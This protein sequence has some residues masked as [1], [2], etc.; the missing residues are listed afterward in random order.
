MRRQK[1]L[2][3]VAIVLALVG[4]ISVYRYL[5]GADQR[6]LAG[7]RP[8]TVLMV[9][10]RI[11]EGTTVAK[12][13]S[14]GYVHAEEVPAESVPADALLTLSDIAQNETALDDV[15]AGQ[16][17]VR[18]MFG[19]AGPTTSGLTIPDGMVAVSVPVNADADV[20]G[21]VQP[22][23]Q[24]ALFDT[25]ILLDDKGTPAGSKDGAT[26][27]DNW[28]TKL[29]LPHVL[30]LAVSQAAP[31]RDKPA[32]ASEAMLVTVAVTQT[33]AERVIHVRQT[34]MLYLALL[35]AHSHTGPTTGVDNQNKLSPLFPP[36][37][38]RQASS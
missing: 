21:Y 23:A 19:T 24:V 32:T 8:S 15:Q 28:A 38:I 5:K 10:K 35:S 4:S 30:V 18:A 7:K 11:P 22:G 20:A 36:S 27:K 16:V 9:A 12:V 3:A 31:T 25:F 14:A 34:G 17:V 1:I 26:A 2:V 13:A 37:V 33:D 6:A 29:L